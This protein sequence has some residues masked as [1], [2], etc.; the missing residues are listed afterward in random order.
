MARNVSTAFS[1][2]PIRRS[3][4]LFLLLMNLSLNTRYRNYDISFVAL[5][6]T[7]LTIFTIESSVARRTAKAGF[8]R[9]SKCEN[10]VWPKPRLYTWNVRLFGNYRKLLDFDNKKKKEKFNLNCLIRRINWIKVQHNFNSTLSTFY[11]SI[12]SEEII[13]QFFCLTITIATAISHYPLPYTI[14]FTA[15]QNVNFCHFF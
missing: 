14:P 9:L 10:G 13:Q 11:S 15:W 3:L 5:K 7:T 4:K 1:E 8:V 6:N 12:Y 2:V